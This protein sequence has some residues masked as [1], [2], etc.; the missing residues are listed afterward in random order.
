MVI[1]P[2]GKQAIGCK[3]MFINLVG[4]ISRLKA[5]LVAKGY[6]QTYGMDY[7]DTFSPVA[8]L[9]SLRLLISLAATFDWPLHQLD[10]KN[11]F[12]NGDLQEKVYIEQPPS[13][14]AQGEYAKV[15]RQG[16]S[17]NGMK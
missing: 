15:C 6:A 16:K 13:F 1:L 2:A 8:K 9:I 5:R 14:V 12:L 4:S 10:I 7:H 11:A 3:W 17:L